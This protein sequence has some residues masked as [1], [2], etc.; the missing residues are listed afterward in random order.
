MLKKLWT[1]M[2][3]GSQNE[4]KM[5]AKTFKISPKRLPKSLKYRG[6]GADAFLERSWAPKGYS[7]VSF[8]GP[9]WE[10]FS[11]KNRKHVIQEGMQNSMPKKYRKLMAKGS[12][13]DTKM[14]A[15]IN[16]SSF[17][18]VHG[19]FFEYHLFP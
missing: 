4:A 17:L 7:H 6:C 15:K 12:Q 13:N 8:P 14:D 16:D 9:F 11:V 3:K 1:L 10:P 19:C 2:L 18:F 5:D